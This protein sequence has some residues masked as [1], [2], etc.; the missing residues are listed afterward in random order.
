VKPRRTA[1]RVLVIAGMLAMLLG[2][3]DP[4]EGSLVILPGSAL[5]AIGAW[6]G[7]GRLSPLPTWALAL[8]AVGVGI[9]FGL[10]AM[11]GVGGTS[12]RPLWWAL[13]V[14]PYPVGWGMGL[15]A[16]VRALLELHRGA[17]AKAA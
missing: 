13:V 9:L 7:R 12:G 3:V 8:V 14:L 5:V 6:F 11:G 17:A 2:A 4:L 1:A 10:S 16:S 15:I